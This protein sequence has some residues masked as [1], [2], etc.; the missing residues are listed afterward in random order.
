MSVAV[1]AERV[2]EHPLL[3]LLTLMMMTQT[4][5][6]P[7]GIAA[8]LTLWLVRVGT[9]MGRYIRYATYRIPLLCLLLIRNI[10][11]PRLLL[12]Y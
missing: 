5:R 7:P 11:R 4:L 12:L 8:F 9:P 10:I 2:N 6:Q 3:I 1:P